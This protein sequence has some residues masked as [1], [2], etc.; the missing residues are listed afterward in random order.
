M[1]PQGLELISPHEYHNE[2]T[3]AA[4]NLLQLNE[5]FDY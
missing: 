4:Q 2:E 3:Q 1:F 5:E